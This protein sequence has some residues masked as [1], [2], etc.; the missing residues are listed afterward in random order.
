MVTSATERLSVQVTVSALA[1]QSFT[2]LSRFV[3]SRLGKT[4]R[5]LTLT[6][7][8]SYG[9][10]VDYNRL[11]SENR[12]GRPGLRWWFQTCWPEI[13]EALSSLSRCRSRVDLQ[14]SASNALRVDMTRASQLLSSPAHDPKRYRLPTYRAQAS[15]GR[16][17]ASRR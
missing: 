15:T 2:A 12:K 7:R 17:L 1:K 8:R 14:E 13:R 4:A 5:T 9:L 6:Q 10:E 3:Q 16:R 11:D